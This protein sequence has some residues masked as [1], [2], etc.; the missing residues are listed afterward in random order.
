M[1]KNMEETLRGESF[2]ADSLLQVLPL[3]VGYLA[4]KRSAFWD[5]KGLLTGIA[6]SGLN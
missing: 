5:L 2:P 4:K 3:I 6:G 1:Q